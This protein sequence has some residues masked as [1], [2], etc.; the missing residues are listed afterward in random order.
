MY[1]VLIGFNSFDKFRAQRISIGTSPCFLLQLLMLFFFL[2][3]YCTC[4]K[5]NKLKSEKRKMRALRNLMQLFRANINSCFARRCLRR[6]RRGRMFTAFLFSHSREKGAMLARSTRGWGV[7]GVCD[8]RDHKKWRGCRH[9]W[10]TVDLLGSSP[11]Y[12]LIT[13][14]LTSSPING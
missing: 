9:L 7:V 2:F 4:N 12:H 14:Y 5:F 1:H 3:Y 8:R 6:R 13:Y 10:K 11:F